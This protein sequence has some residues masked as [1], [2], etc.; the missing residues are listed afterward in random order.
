MGNDEESYDQEYDS[1]EYASELENRKNEKLISVSEYE[2][3]DE[4]SS[5]DASNIRILKDTKI[6]EP[7][8]AM[9]PA[10]KKV[11]KD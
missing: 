1:E 10:I 4:V 6:E 8:G 7:I 3:D 9:I 2:D 11:K 5:L